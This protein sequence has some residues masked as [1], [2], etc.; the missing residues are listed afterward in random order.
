MN[1]APKFDDGP[2]WHGK[3]IANLLL[4][5]FDDDKKP[6]TPLKLQKVMYFCHLEFI[7]NTGLPLVQQEFEAWKYGPV[8]PA[9]YEQFKHFSKMPIQSRALQFDPITATEVTPTAQLEHKHLNLLRE[10]YEIYSPID[11]W[12]LSDISHHPAGP[13]AE[14]LES[15]DNG[16]NINRRISNRLITR[17]L[18]CGKLKKGLD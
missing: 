6:A 8:L 17:W 2:P 13:W 1:A 10:A 16:A 11:E 14:A 9:V 3:A 12:V 15:F 4:D 5:W 7:K 18:A